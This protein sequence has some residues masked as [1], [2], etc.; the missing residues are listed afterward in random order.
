MY[1]CTDTLILGHWDTSEFLSIVDE[2][3]DSDETGVIGVNERENER[4]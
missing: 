3:G 4:G 2:E 1:I